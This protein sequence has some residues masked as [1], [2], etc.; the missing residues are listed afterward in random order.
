MVNH[1]VWV[2]KLKHQTHLFIAKCK[3]CNKTWILLVFSFSS[4]KTHR[5]LSFVL[6]EKHSN[7]AFKYK[8]LFI[9]KVKVLHLVCF[10]AVLW[11]SAAGIMLEQPDSGTYREG[12]E[13]PLQ[14]HILQVCPTGWVHV[15]WNDRYNYC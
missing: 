13:C 15:P 3:Q 7:R 5:L 9:W 11:C 4:E 6:K 10:C 8:Q 1:N 14:Q 12:S 2:P